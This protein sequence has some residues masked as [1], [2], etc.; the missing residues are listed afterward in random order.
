MELP[1]MKFGGGDSGILNVP[2]EVFARKYNPALV[3]QVVVA[4]LAGARMGT[5]KQKT[6]AEVK[7]TTRK[8]FRQKGTGRARGGH[9]STPI[10]RGGGRAFPA[11]PQDNFQHK[12]P[13]KMFRSAM[14]ALL[15]RLAEEGR[16][17]AVRQ[18][19][20]ESMKT[21]DFVQALEGMNAGGKKV[22]MIDTEWEDDN[23]LMASHNVPHVSV[24]FLS[25]LLPSDLLSA[26]V[27]M[28]SERSIA[29][30]AEVWS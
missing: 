15:S 12:L 6:R 13:R 4:S 19:T 21:R 30:C 29:R 10:R 5:R 16:L 8:L 20:M 28:L 1:I 9:S 3:H 27:V 2:D 22:L 18:M 24:Q 26:D 14:A 11:T 17:L 25:Y 7:H 23:V